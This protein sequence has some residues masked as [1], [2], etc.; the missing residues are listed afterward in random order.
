MIWDSTLFQS[1]LDNMHDA[2][3]SVDEAQRTSP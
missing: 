1:V 2:I 3:L